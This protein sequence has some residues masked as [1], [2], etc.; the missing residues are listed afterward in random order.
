MREVPDKMRVAGFAGWIVALFAAFGAPAQAG[1][2]LEPAPAAL[3]PPPRGPAASVVVLVSD[4]RGWTAGADRAARTLAARG[5][6]VVGVSLPALRAQ[7]GCLDAAGPLG[8]LAAL[9]ARAAAEAGGPDGMAPVLAGFGEGAGAVWAAAA[10]GMAA[11]GLATAGFDG[12]APADASWCGVAVEDGRFRIGA[13]APAPWIEAGDGA[14]LAGVEGARALGEGDPRDGLPTAVGLIAGADSRADAAPSLEGLRDLPLTLHEDPEAPPGDALA[15]FISGDGGWARFDAEVADRLAAAGLPV[16]GVSALR[17]FWRERPPARI[18]A[19]MA[20]IAEVH[21]AR[22]G[23]RK[24]ILVGYSMGA[25]VTPFYVPL[26]PEAVR[27]RVAGL[28]LLSPTARTGFEFKLGGWFGVDSGPHDVA[29][30][31]AAT[32]APTLCLHGARDPGAPCPRLPLGAARATELP[33]GHDLG[34]DWDRVAAAIL[35]LAG[36]GR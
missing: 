5:A 34:D 17:Y 25:N 24:L 29:A 31:I 32:G 28:A 30:A 26:L 8:A 6:L 18:A 19:D 3:H 10:Q 16:V 12:A 14:A 9:G 22:L 15:L 23:R 7:E 4:A 36:P 2:A 35:Q 27:A 21:G 13:K 11:K 20:R 33:G 1:G